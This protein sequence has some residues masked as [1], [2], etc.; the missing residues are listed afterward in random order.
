MISN[1]DMT[2]E[3]GKLHLWPSPVFEPRQG[4]D[5]I[6]AI[7]S[8]EDARSLSAVCICVSEDVIQLASQNIGLV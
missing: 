3:E 5:M 7:K 2:R 1:A 8:N 4:S 6:Y